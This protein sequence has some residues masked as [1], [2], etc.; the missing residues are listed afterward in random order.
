MMHRVSKNA[1]PLPIVFRSRASLLL[2]VVVTASVLTEVLPG[3]D[4]NVYVLVQLALGVKFP[5][6]PIG[7]VLMAVLDPRFGVDEACPF[8]ADPPE[9]VRVAVAKNPEYDEFQD[10][11]EAR[12]FD[13]TG[14]IEAFAEEQPARSAD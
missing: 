4:K 11:T 2:A 12:T 13:G 10:D 6:T 9:L 8:G 5:A 3:G 1:M 7:A 14:A